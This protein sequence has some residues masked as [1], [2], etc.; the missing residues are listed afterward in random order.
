MNA[1]SPQDAADRGATE[2][3]PLLV[4]QQLAEVMIVDPLVAGTSQVDHL[5]SDRVAQRVARLSPAVT[6]DECPNALL[7]KSTLQSS[8][9]AGR[10]SQ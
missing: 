1:C 3:N 10:Y 5:I 8:Q 7:S 4:S 9:L 2:L 6:V